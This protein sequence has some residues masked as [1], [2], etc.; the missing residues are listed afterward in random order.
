MRRTIR[1]LIFAVGWVC[2]SSFAQDIKPRLGILDVKLIGKDVDTTLRPILNSIVRKSVITSV[3]DSVD[4]VTG[5]K[6]KQIV[7]TNV[8]SC[9]NGACLREFAQKTD[10]DYIINA[11]VF[12]HEEKWGVV[13]QLA[14]PQKDI[15][16]EPQYFGNEDSL[17]KGLP[18][19]TA[20]LVK[21]LIKG[22]V[23]SANDDNLPLPIPPVG[24]KKVIVI[25]SSD[26]SG[27]SVNIDGHLLC[28]APSS[29]ALMQGEHWVEMGKNGYY[30][31]REKIKITE[32]GQKI[33]WDLSPIQTRLLINAVDDETGADLICDVSIDGKKQG[34]TPF[35]DAVAVGTR[36]IS[37]QSDGYDYSKA[38]EEV[39][40]EGKT[41]NVKVK[42]HKTAPVQ[43][44][45]F[46]W[47]YHPID[48]IADHLPSF[49]NSSRRDFGFMVGLKA[50]QNAAGG[51]A[52]AFH[53]DYFG[54]YMGGAVG[55]PDLSGFIGPEFAVNSRIQIYAAWE[56]ATGTKSD[57]YYTDDGYLMS[58][59]EDD[60][61]TGYEV[62]I[63][64][65][66][67]ADGITMLSVGYNSIRNGVAL[68]VGMGI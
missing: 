1:L 12:R 37:V 25:F 33:D 2:A 18:E 38:I 8:K 58:T 66:P 21:S 62:G 45:E 63:I 34:Q 17:V 7:E 16:E 68:G 14:S 41:S 44:T 6:F 15:A 48:F 19:L 28:E 31:R 27:A 30:T 56:A 4:V 60:D 22:K 20:Q 65:K 36:T 64:F 54:V 3:S 11:E 53:G 23:A 46:H 35:N 5:D 59:T 29:K 42:L 57:D 50:D 55:S 10:V 43:K 51:M 67:F 47:D 32:N 61:Q 52:F 49:D 24:A 26:P 13:M 40:E 39:L 9:F